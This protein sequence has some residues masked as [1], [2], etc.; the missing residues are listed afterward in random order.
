[1][2]YIVILRRMFTYCRSVEYVTE[3]TEVYVLQ[4]FSYS[5]RRGPLPGRHPGRGVDT[6][7]TE[8][9]R[10][11]RSTRRGDKILRAAVTVHFGLARLSSRLVRRRPGRSTPVRP[12][13]AH[14]VRTTADITGHQVSDLE[15]V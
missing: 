10:D 3:F 15:S 5:M 11:G 12:R 13:T 9:H 2:V 4:R 7:D 1:M 14:L 6:T 8:P